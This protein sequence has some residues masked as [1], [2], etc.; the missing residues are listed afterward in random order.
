MMIHTQKIEFAKF[1]VPKHAAKADF[2]E[3]HKIFDSF[4]ECIS[5]NAQIN[6]I[7]S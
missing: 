7:H 5:H 3:F 4:E 1:I 6:Q 2:Q